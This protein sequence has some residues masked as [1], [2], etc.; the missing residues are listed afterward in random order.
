MSNVR[1]ALEEYDGELTQDYKF[2]STHIRREARRELPSPS[3]TTVVADGHMT[4]APT[5]TITYS[6]VVLVIP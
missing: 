2:V 6:S 4:D 1:V 3:E 5:S